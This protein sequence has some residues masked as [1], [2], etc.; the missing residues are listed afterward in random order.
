MWENRNAYRILVG[1]QKEETSKR[2][3][4]GWKDNIKMVNR[5]IGWG[6]MD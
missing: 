4:R 5:E 1:S 3:T 6:G 2:P